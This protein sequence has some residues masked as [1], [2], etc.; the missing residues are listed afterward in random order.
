[1]HFQQVK[2]FL[3]VV[4]PVV[5]YRQQQGCE[6]RSLWR[7]FTT[8]NES[9]NRHTPLGCVASFLFLVYQNQRSETDSMKLLVNIAL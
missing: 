9:A 2:L 8:E 4:D 7:L 6:G 3:S 1:M 5:A